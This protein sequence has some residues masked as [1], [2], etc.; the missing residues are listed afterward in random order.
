MSFL[1]WF[2]YCILVCPVF[3]TFAFFLGF[4]LQVCFIVL[5]FVTTLEL[6][7]DHLL[8]LFTP[9]TFLCLLN[10]QARDV[11]QIM[12]NHNLW[13]QLH[14]VYVYTCVRMYL[15]GVFCFQPKY[16]LCLQMVVWYLFQI[17]S[18]VSCI[19][20]AGILHR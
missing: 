18:A 20:K 14:F 5:Y 4:F 19:H 15:N 16:I 9:P 10:L 13:L 8:F 12:S 1:S 2:Y 3:Y 6:F 17:V 7:Y 11:S